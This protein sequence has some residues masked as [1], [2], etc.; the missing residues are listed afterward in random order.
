[1][2]LIMEQFWVFGYGSLMW[3]PGFDFIRSE[4][5]LVRG[6]HRRLCVYSYVHRG[7]PEQPGLVLGLDR[8]GS[9]HGIGF[10]VALE[11]WDDTLSYLRAREQVTSVYLEKRKT[12][13]L[14]SA[15]QQVEAVTY[16]VDRKHRQYTGHLGDDDLM[17][18][19]KRGQG[20]SGHC[21]DYVMNTVSHLREMKIYDQTLE[22]LARKLDDQAAISTS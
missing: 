19:V 11:K 12:I 21:I 7:T 17:L 22:R 13:T 3:R 15:R 6:Y 2:V 14:L 18:H 5:A 10:Q 1:M 4:P 8:G 9:C 20:V 16:V